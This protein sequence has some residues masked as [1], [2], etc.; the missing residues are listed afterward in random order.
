MVRMRRGGRKAVHRVDTLLTRSARAWDLRPP[1][2]TYVIIICVDT[3]S[4]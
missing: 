2:Y 4:L 1:Q 3:S